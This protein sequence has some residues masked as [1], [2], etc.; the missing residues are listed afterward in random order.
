MKSIIAVLI[1]L[2]MSCNSHSQEQLSHSNDEVTTYY[3]IRHAEKDRSDPTNRNPHLNTKG[4]ERSER[5]NQILEHVKFDAVY[6]TNYFRT[7]ETAQPIADKNKLT[8]KNYNPN[9]LD[10][11]LSQFLKETKGKTVLIVGH[12]NTTPSFV[13]AIIGKN[14]YSDIDDSNNGNLYIVTI[15]GDTVTDQLLTIN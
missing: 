15:V 1:L 6:S 10:N 4:V 5:W 12:S 8:I 7:M 11:E 9:D 2:F 3:L 14:T 13:N